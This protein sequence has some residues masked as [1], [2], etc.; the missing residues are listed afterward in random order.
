M[1]SDLDIYVTGVT[2]ENAVKPDGGPSRGW[3]HLLLFL[4]SWLPVLLSASCSCV[5]ALRC[6]SICSVLSAFLQALPTINTFPKVH[7]VFF[8]P[9]A[10]S[11]RKTHNKAGFLDF[12]LKPQFS[13]RSFLATL[14]KIGAYPFPLHSET[15]LFILYYF[16]KAVI[17]N[18]CVLYSI[19][20]CI[21]CTS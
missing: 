9:G 3:Q 18:S 5:I 19:Y 13:A 11:P 14:L 21:T 6:H 8:L 4:L 10:L 1:G 20:I 17:I 2:G 7:T 15:A 12:F 16:S